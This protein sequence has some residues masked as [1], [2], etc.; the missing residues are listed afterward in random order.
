MLE[1]WP[2][3]PA[4]SFS[5]E[6]KETIFFFVGKQ[7]LPLKALMADGKMV[8][9]RRWT[10]SSTPSPQGLCTQVAIEPLGSTATEKKFLL[11]S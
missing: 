4:A 7:T 8:T 1:S 5:S 9:G 6:K 3:S 11:H 10:G 2:I